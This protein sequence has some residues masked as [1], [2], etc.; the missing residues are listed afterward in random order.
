MARFRLQ[1][2]DDWQ[3]VH[4]EQ[5]VRGWPVRDATGTQIGTV[6]DMIVDDEEE[7]VDMLVLSDGRQVP[8]A[9]VYL[10]DDAVFLEG[11][12]EGAR[13]L[14]TV[15]DDYGRVS[16]RLGVE[17]HD[18]F[19]SH[20]ATAYTGKKYDNYSSAYQYG[21]AAGG[22]KRYAGKA[23]ASVEN[24]LRS[25]YGTRFGDRSFDDDRS[26]IEYGYGYARTSATAT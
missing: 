25:D 20:H 14:V 3:L 2:T 16:R 12:A 10:G 17:D 7:R 9:E 11:G 8:A 1:D 6:D 26:A 5:D 19:R 15:Y 21:Y 18:A 23:F 4:D 13:E 22:H 24:D